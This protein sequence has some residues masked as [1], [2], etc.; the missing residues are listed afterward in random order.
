VMITAVNAILIDAAGSPKQVWLALKQIDPVTRMG[1]F[2]CC[3]DAKNAATNNRNS[4]LA[5]AFMPHKSPLIDSIMRATS[6]A[7]SAVKKLEVSSSND[8]MNVA[9]SC[10][11]GS[12]LD[13]NIGRN[14]ACSSRR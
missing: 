7:I 1:N 9:A 5:H 4:D 11:N 13:S 6:T 2:D 14:P 10:C 8:L 3:R 12:A